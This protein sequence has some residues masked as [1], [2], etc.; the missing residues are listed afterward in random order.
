MREPKLSPEDWQHIR[1]GVA[2]YNTAAFWES[3]E[4][5]E[6]VWRRY[7]DEWRLFLQGLIQMAAGYHQLRRRIFHGVVKHL[8]NARGKLARFPEGFLG[9]DTDALLAG[10]DQTLVQV[11]A[12]GRHGLA[13]V[14]LEIFPKIIFSDPTENRNSLA[15]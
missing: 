15:P 1:D 14:P 10:I 7:P 2:L 4:A 12:G 5:W 6:I 8:R 11:E 9:I 13:E 3:H